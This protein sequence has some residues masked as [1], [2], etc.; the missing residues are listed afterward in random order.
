MIILVL[1]TS[2]TTNKQAR[3]EVKMEKSKKTVIKIV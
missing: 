3:R 2:S 1:L